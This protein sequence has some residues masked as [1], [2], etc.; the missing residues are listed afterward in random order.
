MPTAV[1]VPDAGT[2]GGRLTLSFNRL[3][4][5]TDL[6]L[7]VQGADCPAGP[8]S[9]LAISTNG[10][11]VIPLTGGVTV[12]ETGSGGTRL[13]QVADLFLMGDPNHPGRFMRLRVTRP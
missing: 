11:A 6:T 1:P 13:V 3:P 5:N 8:W 10:N 2:S 4:G 9:N 12:T 7:T